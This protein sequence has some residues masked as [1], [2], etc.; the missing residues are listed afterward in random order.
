MFLKNP[1]L[2]R[3]AGTVVLA[4]LLASGPCACANPAHMGSGHS[5]GGH[6]SSRFDQM[7][8]NRDGK[9]VLEEFRTAFPN[10]NEQA[11][12]VIDTDGNKGIDRAEWFA[13]TEGHARGSI[14]G[15]GHAPR[16]DNIPGDP[17]IPPPDSNDLPLVL[18]P[19]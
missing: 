19:N 6:I 4:G 2:S 17:L 5:P 10:M 3:A 13:F 15:T 14:P 18:P 12:A 9:V 8:A 11:F 16:L 1:V 7:D